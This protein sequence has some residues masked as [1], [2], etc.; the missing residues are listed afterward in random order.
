MPRDNDCTER[1][2]TQ[3]ARKPHEK[4]AYTIDSEREEQLFDRLSRPR[5]LLG[6]ENFNFS[7]DTLGDLNSINISWK[8]LLQ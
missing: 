6:I 1:S 3:R 4:L 8:Q 5:D 2:R 7:E